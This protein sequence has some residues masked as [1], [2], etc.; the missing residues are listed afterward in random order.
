MG[1]SKINSITDGQV[2]AKDSA[3]SNNDSG[4]PIGSWRENS[5]LTVGVIDN[6]SISAGER[7]TRRNIY[8]KNRGWK[9]CCEHDNIYP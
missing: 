7:R 4:Q 3:Q 2:A 6:R 9:S 8:D 1:K 5:Q